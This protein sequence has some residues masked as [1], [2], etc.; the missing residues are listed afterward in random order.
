MPSHINHIVF[1]ERFLS[2]EITGKK[3]N[4]VIRIVTKINYMA[5]T[6]ARI[7]CIEF[8]NSDILVPIITALALVKVTSFDIYVKAKQT[9]ARINPVVQHTISVNDKYLSCVETEVDL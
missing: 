7:K 3:Y 2:A 5:E 8:Q 6:E 1:I 4:C 9:G